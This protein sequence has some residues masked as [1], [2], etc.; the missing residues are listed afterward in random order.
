MN[1]MNFIY[2]QLANFN[3]DPAQDIKINRLKDLLTLVNRYKYTVNRS[4]F[5]NTSEHIALFSKAYKLVINNQFIYWIYTFINHQL[6][7]FIIT[8]SE[9]KKIA[10]SIESLLFQLHQAKLIS[11]QNCEII[12]SYLFTSNQFIIDLCCIDNEYVIKIWLP[13]FASYKQ[14]PISNI[15]SLHKVLEIFTSESIQNKCESIY[16][17]NRL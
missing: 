1:F 7:I 10:I 4:L 2:M 9:L 12:S 13:M 11:I 8:E 16:L 14:Y 6:Y 5:F 15:E 3:I 17:L